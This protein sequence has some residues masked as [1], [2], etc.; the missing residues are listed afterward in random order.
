MYRGARVAVV[1][2]AYHE[3]RLLGR[4]LAGIPAYVDCVVVVDDAS[5][6]DT[7]H[8]AERRRDQRVEVVVHAVNR[9]VGA[10]IVTGYARALECGAELIAVM[11]AD[12]QM[13]PSDLPSLL[14][15]ALDQ[16]AD[17]VKGNRFLHERRTDMPL[18]RRTAGRLLA[19]VT[20]WAAGVRIGDSQC[21]YTVLCAPVAEELAGSEVWPRYGYPN[22]VIVLLGRRGRR[23]TE[24]PVRPVYADEASGIR[25]W[26][27]LTV[28]GVIARRVWSE[29]SVGLAAQH[30]R[31]GRRRAAALESGAE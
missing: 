5:Q 15:A 8:V 20:S 29:R 16:G 25:F 23:I 10:A 12:D 19:R 18:M 7:R 17:Y 27:A 28:L 2:P 22:D 6:D 21:G 9:G 11:A 24:V 30:A 3:E 31:V 14:D 26:H 4:T 1:I 13:D